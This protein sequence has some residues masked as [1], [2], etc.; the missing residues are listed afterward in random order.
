MFDAKR[1]TR[2]PVNRHPSERLKKD[3]ERNDVIGRQ[4]NTSWHQ[5]CVDQLPPGA[6]LRRWSRV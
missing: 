5:L 2:E 1:S 3:G 6:V 4:Q